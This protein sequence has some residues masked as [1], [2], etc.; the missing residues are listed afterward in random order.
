MYSVRLMDKKSA[1]SA[2]PAPEKAKESS[3]SQAK[4]SFEE[5][6]SK[7]NEPAKPEEEKIVTETVKRKVEPQA[8]DEPKPTKPKKV[9]PDYRAETERLKREL[10]EAKAKL[11]PPKKEEPKTSD[12]DTIQAELSEQFGE[13]EGAILGKTLRALLEPR[14]QRISQLE[15]LIERAVEQSKIQS[16]KANRTRISKEYDHLADDDDAWEIVRSQADA[17]FAQGKHET[18]DE[19]YEYVANALYGAVKTKAVE[20]A[21]EEASRIAASTPTQPSSV[22]RERKMTAEAASRASFDHLL[23]NPNDVEGARRI[24]SQFKVKDL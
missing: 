3:L 13:E 11:E 4:K 2:T 1:P 12:Y 19:A 18:Q 24:S 21:E 22:R 6:L 16:A 20:D 14:E 5:A 7:L 8:E 10:A 15:K 9:E 23:K 17:R